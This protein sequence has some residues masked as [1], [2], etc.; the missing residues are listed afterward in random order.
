M[1]PAS[2]RAAPPRDG[3]RKVTQ[4]LGRTPN[5]VLSALYAG[6]SRPAKPQL[7]QRVLGMDAGPTPAGVRLPGRS[8][9]TPEGR[10]SAASSRPATAGLPARP[11]NS[12]DVL[13]A[14]TSAPTTGPTFERADPR[15]LATPDEIVTP[16]VDDLP[17]GLADTV[18]DLI[19][20]PCARG[21]IHL[22]SAVIAVFGGAALVSAAWIASSPKAV[23]ATLIYTVS[24]VAMFSVSAIY[25]RKHWHSRP[26]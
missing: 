18:A 2:Y 12:G 16:V 7:V 13:N 20:R 4:C 17:Q 3:E 23:L 6:P 24:I 11:P 10:L 5:R 15:V 19:G 8:T 25:H 26:R 21:W 14:R 9:G 22:C 1:S